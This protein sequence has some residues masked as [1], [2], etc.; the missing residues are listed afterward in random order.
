MYVLSVEK[1]NDEESAFY[2]GLMSQYG[3]GVKEDLVAASK[4]YKKSSENYYAI[5]IDDENYNLK[6]N[7]R[8]FLSGLIIDDIDA[9]K[10]IERK[11]NNNYGFKS[12]K[13]NYFLPISC[14]DFD[15]KSYVPSDYI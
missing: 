14:G 8:D 15:Y 1:D 3:V 10:I 4:W 13:A 9:K 12:H 5:A 6:K 2:L 7:R 11:I